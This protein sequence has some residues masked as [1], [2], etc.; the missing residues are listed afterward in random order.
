MFY[1]PALFFFVRLPYN[2]FLW[3][4]G[5]P[6]YHLAL[7]SIM[8]YLALSPP[9]TEEFV[10]NNL[11]SV[12]SWRE[13]GSKQKESRPVTESKNG[14]EAVL[15]PKSSGRACSIEVSVLRHGGDIE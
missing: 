14:R 11:S 7:R 4:H 1:N 13:H 10:K 9:L 15:S 5:G 3:N 2:Y 6:A 12:L 8:I